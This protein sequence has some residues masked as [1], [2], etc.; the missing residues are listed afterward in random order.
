VI[1][2]LVLGI[3]QG[4]T[5]FLPVSSSGHLVLVERLLGFDPPGVLLEVLL[6]LATLAAVVALFHRDLVRLARSLVRKEETEARRELL[7]LAVATVPIVFLGLFLQKAIVAAFS[8]LLVVG[9]SLFATGGMLLLASRA[10]P[11]ARRSQVRFLDAL[12]IGLAQGAALLPGISRSGATLSAGLLRGVKGKEAARFSFLLS[13]PAIL[14][15]GI[16]KVPEALRSSATSEVAWPAL[17]VAMLVAALVG[18]LAIRGLLAALA[19]G[20]LKWFGVYCLLV[21]LATILVVC[22]R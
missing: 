19:R 11:G 5:E 12:T 9:I 3:V 1:H 7:L 2:A 21:G 13:I 8:S 20:K 17:V 18:A 4:L 10:A 15:A 6:H 16:L 14:G 22:L